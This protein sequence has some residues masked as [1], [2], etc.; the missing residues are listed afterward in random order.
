[1]YAR[2]LDGNI[3]ELAIYQCSGAAGELSNMQT[4]TN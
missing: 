3:E 1:M 4:I 2:A